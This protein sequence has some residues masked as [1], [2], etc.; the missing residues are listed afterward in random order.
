[1][2]EH[3]QHRSLD[4]RHI[5]ARKKDENRVNS[6]LKK[7]REEDMKDSAVEFGTQVRHME[8][9]T[10]DL[11]AEEGLQERYMGEEDTEGESYRQHI[12]HE[13]FSHDNVP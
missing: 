8:N 13:W 6:M 12:I 10:E 5:E 3:M 2:E 7:Y 11:Y 4:G 1:M 9:G